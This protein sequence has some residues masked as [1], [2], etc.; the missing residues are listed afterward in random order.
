[1]KQELAEQKGGIIVDFNTSFS[2][3]GRSIRQNQQGYIVIQH[4]QPKGF[5]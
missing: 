4:H 1:M 5:N 3:I 2:T